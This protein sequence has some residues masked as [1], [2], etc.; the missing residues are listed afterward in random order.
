[1]HITNFNDR[2]DGKLHYNTGEEFKLIKIIIMCL[3]CDRDIIHN[4]KIN[5]FSGNNLQKKIINTF[6]NFKLI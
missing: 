2:F 1:M 3:P 6:S 4:N 5:D